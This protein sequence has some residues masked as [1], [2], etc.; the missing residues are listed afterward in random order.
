MSN[1]RSLLTRLRKLETSGMNPVL[2]KLGS[3]EQF[4]DT[5]N[6]AID[7]KRVCAVDGPFLIHCVRRWVNETH[8]YNDGRMIESW[9]E[10]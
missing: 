8:Q 10:R 7:E 2:K 3:L 5:V 6:R 4:A 9:A 1:A